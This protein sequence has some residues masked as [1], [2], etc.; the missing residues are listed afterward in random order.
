MKWSER[1]RARLISLRDAMFQ[2]QGQGVFQ[3]LQRDFV[4]NQP[5][6]NLWAGIREDAID[7]FRRHRIS[8]WGGAVDEPTGHLLS[9]QVA[10]VNHLYPLRQRED[11]VLAL[12]AGLDS[13]IVA[14]ERVD[15][16]YIAFEFIG[17]RQY[18][19]ER[20]FS[21]GAHCTSVDAAMI[22]RTVTGDRRIFLIEWKYVEAYVVKNQYVPARAQVYDALIL[23]PDSPFRPL[24]PRC[25]YY[26]PFYQLMRQTLLG[27][28]IARHEDHG[29]TSY[30]HVHVAPD[31]NGEF[32]ASVTSKTLRGDTVYD[33]WRSSLKNDEL[34]L[35]RS[36]Q[37]L[38]EPLT[39]LPDTGSHTAYLAARYWA[40]R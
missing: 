39:G 28:L 21:R 37:T 4:L 12:L 11:L 13:T 14:A 9:S 22:G 2:D 29:C 32:H 27:A 19:K 10:C 17:D 38:F 1:E 25:F 35:T 33:A 23:A 6:R 15:D 3:G 36:P 24:D 7:Y 26:E 5:A 8:W 18:L 30:R 20:G 34:F 40:G 16:G 31:E